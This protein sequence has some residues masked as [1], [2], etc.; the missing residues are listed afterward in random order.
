MSAA[1]TDNDKAFRALRAEI[2]KLAK[3][4]ITVGVHGD[5]RERDGGE[6][7]NVQLAAVHEF[8]SPAQGIPA[9][10]FLRAAVDEHVGQL[11][12]VG[13]ELAE[14]VAMATLT[15]K[16][17]G[18]QLGAFAVGLIQARMSNGLKPPLSPKTLVKRA[19][20]T[21][22]GRSALAAIK[23]LGAKVRGGKALTGKQAARL[24][25]ARAL[26]T[27]ATPLIDTGQLRQSIA[28]KVKQ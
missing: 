9:R 12:E 20:R 7:D 21:K 14:R 13:G 28:Y 24:G 23:R 3:T 5:E 22:R 2:A 27:N 26:V 6:I 17:A 11:R 16:Q 10:S 18:A 8:G 25:K 1:V 15:A 19:Q 4:V